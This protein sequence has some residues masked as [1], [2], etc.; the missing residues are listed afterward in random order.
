[1]VNVKIE[2]QMVDV[3]ME[4]STA[5]GLFLRKKFIW[6]MYFNGWQQKMK[7]LEYQIIFMQSQLK[8]ITKGNF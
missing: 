5:N 6:N 7:M 8:G 4:M 3:D 1:M 2:V